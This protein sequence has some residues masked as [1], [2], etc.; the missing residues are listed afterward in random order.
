MIVIFVLIMTPFAELILGRRNRQQ[1]Q[2]QQ[3][4]VPNARTGWPNNV[5]HRKDNEFA[6]GRLTRRLSLHGSVSLTI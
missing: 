5:R 3:A 1:N 2:Q 6:H 4:T